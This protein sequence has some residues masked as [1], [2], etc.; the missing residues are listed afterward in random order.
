VAR[1]PRTPGARERAPGRA[2]VD[3][4]Y[5]VARLYESGD[6]GIPPDPTEAYKWYLIAARAGDG[7]AQSAVERLRGTLKADDRGKARAD[8]DRFQVEPIA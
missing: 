4:Q 7:D 5:N 8:A 2:L 1:A 6:E 3:S